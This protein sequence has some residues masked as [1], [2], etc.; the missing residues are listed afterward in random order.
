MFLLHFMPNPQ[1]VL[2]NDAVFFVF[3]LFFIFAFRFFAGT[4]RE[5]A[6]RGYLWYTTMMLQPDARP[7]GKFARN[8]PPGGYPFGSGE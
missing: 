2:Q 8:P 6:G 7:R 4:N 3:L 1:V 5:V